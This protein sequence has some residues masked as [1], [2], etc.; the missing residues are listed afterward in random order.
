MTQLIDKPVDG[1]SKLNTEEGGWLGWF[2]GES[3][4]QLISFKLGDK[5]VGTK[6]VSA[7][8]STTIFKYE[9]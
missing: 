9:R 4:A 1:L 3:D 7:E 5:G 8:T 2:V 6:A